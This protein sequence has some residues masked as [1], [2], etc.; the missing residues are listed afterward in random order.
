MLYGSLGD[1]P[2]ISICFCPDVDIQTC[3]SPRSVASSCVSV[4]VSG[5]SGFLLPYGCANQVHAHTGRALKHRRH[6]QA[7]AL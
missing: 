5:S 3:P 6:V 7:S 4:A 2:P 1:S